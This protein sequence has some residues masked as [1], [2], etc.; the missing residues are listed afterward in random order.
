M[1]PSPPTWQGGPPPWLQGDPPPFSGAWGPIIVL[2]CGAGK[3]LVGVT[4][5][6]TLQKRTLVLCLN[7][8][9]GPPPLPARPKG[10]GRTPWACPLGLVLGLGQGGP[11][12]NPPLFWRHHP[13]PTPH[14]GCP[15]IRSP[16]SGGKIRKREDD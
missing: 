13:P 12:P 2:P 7:T 4:A 14:V 8:V 9:P 6:A 5:A 16:E 11:V 10:P 1:P 15:E 3:T